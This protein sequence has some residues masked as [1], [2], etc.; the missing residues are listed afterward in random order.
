[1]FAYH[2]QIVLELVGVV[3]GILE[4]SGG[5]TSS[6]AAVSSKATHTYNYK[7]T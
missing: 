4:L 5:R 6:A 2:G 1:M 7:L 3:A